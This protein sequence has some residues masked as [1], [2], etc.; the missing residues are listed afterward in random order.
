MR[1]TA[2]TF[3]LL[4]LAGAI[5]GPLAAQARRGGAGRDRGL[6]ELTPQGLRSG[7]FISGGIGAGREQ[8][9][10]S[11]ENVGYSDALE[12]PTGMLRL[13]GTP[14][15]NVRLG[16]ELFGWWSRTSD[17]AGTESFG[18]MLLSAQF[19]PMTNGGLY[20]K[21]GGGLGSSGFDP[22]YGSSNIET[23]FAWS[24]GAGWDIP[25]SRQVS[26]APTIDFYRGTFTRRDE[27][28]LYDRVLNIGAQVTFQTGNRFRR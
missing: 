20:V 15:A 9:R 8:F 10:F 11:D 14:N 1:R 23:G 26:I 19:Y 25:L 4:T 18:A 7:F 28:T 3:A 24:V 6:V 22:D 16:G 5:A 12:K 21:A 13:G 17:P 2:R 27:G